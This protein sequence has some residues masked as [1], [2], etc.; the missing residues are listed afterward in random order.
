MEAPLSQAVECR[1][2]ILCNHEVTDI[3]T[4]VIELLKTN[5]NLGKSCS[6]L[7]NTPHTF[8]SSTSLCLLHN[9]SIVQLISPFSQERRNYRDQSVR[10]K[11]RNLNGQ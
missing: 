1:A 2:T 3:R 11:V 9:S 5:F 8:G 6:R 7:T 10:T 4:P